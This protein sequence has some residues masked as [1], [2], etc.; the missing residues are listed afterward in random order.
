MSFA[1]SRA[2]RSVPSLQLF[3]CGEIGGPLSI[4]ISLTL[5]LFCSSRILYGP[6]KRSANFLCIR[7]RWL[8]STKTVSPGW[9]LGC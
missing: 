5:L 8:V 9:K 6:L 7:L 4:G 2:G 1:S 3:M